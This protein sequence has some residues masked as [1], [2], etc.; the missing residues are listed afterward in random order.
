MNWIYRLNWWYDDQ[1]EPYRFLMFIIPWV[2]LIFAASFSGGIGHLLGLATMC[3][4]GILRIIPF[5][6]PKKRS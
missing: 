4:I 2:I 1:Q 3:I 6:F 5:A